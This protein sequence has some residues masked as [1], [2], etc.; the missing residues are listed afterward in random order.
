MGHEGQLVGG[1]KAD[2]A[3]G[4]RVGLE[5]LGPAI[6]GPFAALRTT[7]D[8]LDRV[9]AQGEVAE[10]TFFFRG[11]EGKALYD[12]ARNAGGAGTAGVAVLIVH[13]HPRQPR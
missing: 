7:K 13:P 1:V 8:A 6:A 11:Q 9:R 10:A 3:A 2:Q 5:H 12:S 4:R